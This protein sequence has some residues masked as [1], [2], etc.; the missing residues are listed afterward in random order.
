MPGS[1]RHALFALFSA[2]G[3]AYLWPKAGFAQNPVP[4]P[5]KRPGDEKAPGPFD[6]P[7]NSTKTLLEQNQKELKKD[8][9]KLYELAAQLKTEIEKTDS[10]AVLSVTLVKKAEEVEKLAKQIKER[11]KG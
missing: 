8:V 7:A 5:P 11:A 4:G 3:A 2:L 6:L 10:S 9:E 1:R